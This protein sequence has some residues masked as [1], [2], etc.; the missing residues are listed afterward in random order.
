MTDVKIINPFTDVALLPMAT[1]AESGQ[2][3]FMSNLKELNIGDGGNNVFRAD[4]NGVWLGA[5]TFTAA[6][7]SVSM[8]GAITASSLTLIGGIIRYGKISW[9]DSTHAGYYIGNEGVY[10]S[11]AADATLFKFTIASGLIDHIGTVSGR[12]TAILASA[13]DAAGHFADLAISTATKT[14]LGGF[15]F[16]STDFSGA[17]KTGDIT[18]NATTGAITGGSGVVVNKAGIIGATAGVVTFSI[19]GV[20]GV[21]TGN[22][23]VVGTNVG[24]G[25]AQTAG[26]VTTIIGGTVTTS[27]VN[28]LGVNAASVSAS[29]SITSPVITGGTITGTT[30]QTNVATYPYV[31]MTASGVTISGTSS[32]NFITSAGAGCGYIG[33][34]A[35]YGM[36]IA[37]TAGM[38][39]MY[40]R[41]GISIGTSASDGTI[42]ISSAGI[43][44]DPR[45]AMG[46]LAVT[47]LGRLKIPVGSNLY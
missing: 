5:K 10:F 24:L 39:T 36:D 2:G 19:N 42:D 25:T 21:I 32:L 1:P 12:S 30:I 11:S 14:I 4:K 34:D 35:T 20:T 26:N 7:F 18:W 16:G 23:L 45:G 6:P 47:I 29:I 41:Y 9:A 3:V 37:N 44:L 38:I 31:K 15:T 43:L 27:F 28:A 33:G 13:I 8:A 17:L 22:G 40:G 46:D